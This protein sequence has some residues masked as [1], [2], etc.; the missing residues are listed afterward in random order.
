[1]T[2][3]GHDTLPLATMDAQGG[4][5]SVLQEWNLSSPEQERDAQI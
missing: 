4:Y 3:Q 2:V 1:M 5:L